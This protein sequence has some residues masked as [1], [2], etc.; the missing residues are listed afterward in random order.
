MNII[1][2]Q[3]ETLYRNNEFKIVIKGVKVLVSE[4]SEKDLKEY[5]EI[6]E[7]SEDIKILFV[8]P[9]LEKAVEIAKR[10]LKERAKE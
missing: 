10:E 3:I 1:T 7:S 4:V 6:V 2:S 5:I 9:I 8:K